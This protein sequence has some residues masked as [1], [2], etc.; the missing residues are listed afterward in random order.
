MLWLWLV[1]TV[2]LLV[3][4]HLLKWFGVSRGLPGWFLWLPSTILLVWLAMVLVV[5]VFA[6]TAP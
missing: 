6:L 5:V 3:T 2:L 4:H 1:V